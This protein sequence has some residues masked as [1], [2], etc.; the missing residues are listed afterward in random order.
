MPWH[1]VVGMIKRTYRWPLRRHLD[2]FVHESAR[3]D[4]LTSARHRSFL[5]SHT[6]G[7]GL[8]A[9]GML[10]YGMLS[11]DPSPI[12][13]AALAW[14][15]LPVF[16]A[17]LLWRT[18]RLAAAHFVSA[19]LFASLVGG[20]A[21]ATGGIYSFALFWLLAVPVEAAMSGSRKVVIA[22]L[23]VCALVV[24]ALALAGE[25]SSLPVWH[26][27][28]ERSLYY[29]VL[30]LG[31]A[32]VYVGMLA[33]TIEYHY[34][35]STAVVQ[36][37]T[38][39]YRL[40]AENAT[41]MIT[42]HGPNGEVQFVS[43]AFDR[44]VHCDSNELLGTGLMD[45]VHEDDR[46]VYVTAFVKAADTGGSASAE[47]R[48]SVDQSGSAGP[49]NYRWVELNCRPF[50]DPQQ[51]GK[52]C[53]IV[54]VTRD[55]SGRK[56]RQEE[57]RAARDASEA[58]N[59]AKTHF[60]AN[61]S[62]ELRTPL[63]SIIGFAEVLGNDPGEG[64]GRE[65]REEYASHI[66]QSGA[67]LL[68][69]VNDLLDMSRIEAGRIAIDAEAIDLGEVVRFC[70][71][72]LSGTAKKRGVTISLDVPVDGGI[73]MADRKACTQII[74]NLLSNAIKFSES[75]SVVTVKAASDQ[76]S[77]VIAVSDKGA[78]MPAE[79]VARAGQIF[80]QGDNAYSRRHEGAGL[81]LAIVRGLVEM[82]GGELDID[83]ALGEGTCV[84]V[85]LP[86]KRADIA[87]AEIAEPS[88]VERE[89][90]DDPV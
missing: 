60:L 82:H 55:I 67:H 56:K 19:A 61:M 12:A 41:D 15:I 16:A 39:S 7:A 69:V 45:L 72:A 76:E 74:L 13:L 64:R 30:G 79:L 50:V 9:A 38:E 47:F 75:G 22:A 84:T 23:N 71:H 4:E 86:C 59:H 43:G 36:D 8:A 85:R 20:V 18:G 27:E 42:R 57:L 3:G 68:G 26:G 1:A 34:G 11:P 14:M 73:V 58:A 32:L 80:T 5:I 90:A 37:K 49:E 83:S 21:A 89:L 6:I 53:Q 87:H 65:I 66:R 46:H 28:A 81:G 70:E 2:N 77:C 52:A 29:L 25:F 35:K 63:N 44:L 33:A 10:A 51:A 31:G 88:D 48:L 17:V 54:A 78:G 24:A 62:H 40:L